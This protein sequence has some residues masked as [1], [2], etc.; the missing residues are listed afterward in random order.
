[1]PGPRHSCGAREPSDPAAIGALRELDE[2]GRMKRAKELL[3][4]ILLEVA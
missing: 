2:S 3:R 1:V 4:E